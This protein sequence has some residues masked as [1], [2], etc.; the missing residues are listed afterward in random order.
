MTRSKSKVS[1]I[2]RHI[3]VDGQGLPHAIQRDYRR[4]LPIRAG[5]DRLMF[6]ENFGPTSEQVQ[7]RGG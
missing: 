5:G 4:L 1:R 7:N 3:A 2:K 6:D